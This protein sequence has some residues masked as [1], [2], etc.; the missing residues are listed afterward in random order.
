MS[1]QSTPPSGTTTTAVSRLEVVEDLSDRTGLDE[2]FLGARVPVPALLD[3]GVA[4]VTLPYTHFTVVMRPDRRLA[5]VTGVCIDGATLVDVSRDGVRWRLDPRLPEADQSGEA[6]YA[7]NDLDRGHLVRRRDPVWGVP[8][9]AARA[10][11]DTFHYTNAAPQAAAFNQGDELWLGLETYLLDNATAGRRRLVVFTGPVLDDADPVYRGTAIP[12]RF[13]K[14]AAFVDD[15]DL[16]A[17]AY[18]L[19]QRPEL[20]DV[21]GRSAVLDLRDDAPPPLGPYRTYQ[22]PVAD[23]AALAGLDLD[24]LAAVDRFPTLGH[25]SPREVLAGRPP[26]TWRRL[27]SPGDITWQR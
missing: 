4:T 13:Y 19:D 26:G 18:V 23:V 7:D 6:L 9:V 3:P 14:V 5:A 1:T 12:L 16:A 2:D 11:G 8:D 17:T 10:N 22:V 25:A 21:A 15:G 20:G 27:V 24:G